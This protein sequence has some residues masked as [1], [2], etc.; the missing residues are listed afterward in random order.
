MFLIKEYGKACKSASDK[1]TLSAHLVDVIMMSEPLVSE[2]GSIPNTSQPTTS[3]QP[4]ITEHDS[5]R[6]KGK[7]SRRNGK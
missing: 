4:N 3:Q 6:G 7:S 2:A 1:A 5:K